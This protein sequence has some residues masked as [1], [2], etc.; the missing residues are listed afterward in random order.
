MKLLAAQNLVFS[1]EEGTAIDLDIKLSG[2][3]YQDA[4]GQ[5]FWMPFTARSDD[6]EAHGRQIYEAAISGKLGPIQPYTEPS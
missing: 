3:A 2:K 1:N 4:K 6:P 5:P